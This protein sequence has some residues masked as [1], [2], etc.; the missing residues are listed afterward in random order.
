M[1]L[2]IKI[3][4]TD[5]SKPEYQY[6]KKLEGIFKEAEPSINGEVIIRSNPILYGQG[7]R[8]ELDIVV[9]CKLKNYLPGKIKF[10]KSDN[11]DKNKLI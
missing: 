7:N 11:K 10:F 5:K 1:S 6:A 9:I 2:D 3:I 8:E 4:E